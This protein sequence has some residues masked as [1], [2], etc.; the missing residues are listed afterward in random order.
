MVVA[1]LFLLVVLAVVDSSGTEN[2]SSMD[3]TVIA[4]SSSSYSTRSSSSRCG[5]TSTT[6]VHSGRQLFVANFCA[7]RQSTL[8]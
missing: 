1:H 3:A 8:K 6:R 4:A 5:S 2:I 7:I